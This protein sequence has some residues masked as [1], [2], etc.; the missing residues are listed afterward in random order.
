MTTLYII[1]A[2]LTLFVIVP[3]II[4]A[5]LYERFFSKRFV[6]P[7]YRALDPA[8]YPRL[9]M[10]PHEF[11]SAGG[12]LLKACY[13]TAEGV[14]PAATVVMSHGFGGGGYNCYLDVIEYFAGAGFAV[15]AF[16]GTGNDGSEGRGVGGLPQ[17][18]SDL[19]RAIGYVESAGG[20]PKL[21]VV[22]WGH[23]WGGYCA[24]AVL[25]FRPEVRAAASFAGF[26]RTSDLIRAK[27]EGIIGRWISVI[28]PYVKVYEKLKYGKYGGVTVSDV[29][30]SVK[31]PVFFAHGEKDTV[32]PAGYGYSLWEK[33]FG[34][35]PRFTFVMREGYAHNNIYYSEH[36]LAY[37]ND[38]NAEF[39]RWT[40]SLGYDAAAKEN[41]GRFAKDRSE[42]MHA[43]ID[44]SIWAHKADGEFL[45]GVAGFFM[46]NI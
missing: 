9:R 1:A 6:T 2:A 40:R 21:P 37:V 42:Y 36:A 28:M 24:A 20:I 25:R 5:V 10:A 31:T 43:H 41:A 7:E 26:D 27:G 30:T 23:S 34:G 14:E 17:G 11:R 15:F 13:F 35:D 44:R 4:T 3:G 38:Y 8:E 12:D 16:D 29:L 46:R 18:L 33:K 45:A 19:D 32:I 22:V 39:D